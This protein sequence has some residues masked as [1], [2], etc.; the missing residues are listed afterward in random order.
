[1]SKNIETINWFQKNISETEQLLESNIGKGL[2]QQKVAEKQE[3]CGTNEITES[4]GRSPL[5]IIAEQLL[6]T[7]VII[8]IAATLISAFLGD[9][10]EV[11]AI[12]AIV[13]LFVVLGFTQEYKAEKAMAALKKLAVP[14]VRVLRGRKEEEISAT[15]L[16]P[17]DIIFLE[18]G[19][20]VPADTRIIES[21]NLRI[22]ESALTGESEPI[23]KITKAL[24]AE[25]PPL[26]DRKNMAYMGT[27]VTYGRGKAIVTATG[28]K[29]ELG[30]IA[31]LIQNVKTGLTPLQKQLDS[32][33]KLLAFAGCVVAVIVMII[34]F[35][36]GG[37]FEQML[38]T[39]VS[40]AVAVVPEGL[41]AVVTITLA[42]GAQRMLK[43]RA[44]IRKLPAVETLGSVNIICSD[45][46]GTLT[47]NRMTVTI[48]DIAG[49]YLDIKE[50]KGQTNKLAENVYDLFENWPTALGLTLTG[51]ALCN[52]S[53]I[54][55]GSEEKGF[56][57]HGDPTEGALLV[58]AMKAGLLKERIETVLPRIDE[59]P[60]ESERKRMTTIHEVK[61]DQ[62]KIP[63]LLK[64]TKLLDSKYL[65]F[66]K[67]SVDGLL[68]VA[69][70]VLTQNGVEELTD[71]LRK[72]IEE[73]NNNLASKGVRV[74]GVAVRP[75]DTVEKNL[76]E[77]L[78]FTGLVGM[79]DPPRQEV[80]EAVHT[81]KTAGIRPIMITGDHPLT[82]RF[83][84]EELGISDN[85]LVKTG[86][87]L[88]KIDDNELRNVVKE[89]SVYA[90][91]SPEHKL[92]IVGAL[93][94][95]GNV[96]GMTGDGVNDSPALKK[97]DIG[98]AMGITGTDVSKE[99]SEMVL[100]D[101]NFAT[102]VASVEE[103]RVI[104]DNI[105]RF[106][107]Y[108]VAGNI[109]K[110]L[111]MLF[112]PIFCA[113]I[114]LLPLQ[115][116]WLNLLT[117]GLLGLGLGVEAAEKGVM[118]RKPRSVKEKMF[119]GEDGIRVIWVGILI[120]IVALFTGWIYYSD[121]GLKWQTMMFTVITFLQIGQAL[122]A[123]SN[124]DS[125]FRS[126]FYSNPLLVWMIVLT[127][128]LQ[129]AILYIPFF[130][131]IFKIVPLSFL[132][133]VVCVIFGSITLFA[134]EVVKKIKSS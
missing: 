47:Q 130:A 93:Q 31:T 36:M 48:L 59:L 94:S 102:I 4:G 6:S 97:A 127:V 45:K 117:D 56:S 124:T 9:L 76:E 129:L 72:R 67:G 104:Y 133:V 105:K 63:K 116:L 91:V 3:Q 33:G 27:I 23:E 13:V 65:A 75:L 51:G 69:E 49:K 38:L 103:G 118:K 115:L 110:V 113:T 42:L 134:I 109:G 62:T 15:E 50:Q 25:N 100:L 14:L 90:R 5:K 71:E 19:N 37:T 126:K 112:A 17:G 2:D 12:A 43:R 95:L 16:V 58:A 84:A 83:I 131:G 132:D 80:K 82:A 26:G 7:M 98:I 40:V 21:A 64:Q 18:A 53:S 10:T 32:V 1:M 35:L 111:V 81:C 20:I 68:K 122:G 114:A 57:F 128:I 54:K 108:S 74:L 61:V 8:L 89:V 29:T 77:K 30:K 52:D 46:T 87:E 106:L 66:T 92:K 85:G 123:R 119:S 70:F 96:V 88:D 86:I 73:S 79:I 41:P 11:I 44:L 28:M 120:G 78:I 55:E 60:F 24:D 22:Q 99:A 107:Y 121:S 125:I 101:D 34:G 39:A